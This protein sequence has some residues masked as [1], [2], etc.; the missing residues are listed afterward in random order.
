[1]C[2]HDLI[3]PDFSNTR[4]QF[5]ACAVPAEMLQDSRADHTMLEQ[6]QREGRK[7]LK[8]GHQFA[9]TTGGTQ[10]MQHSGVWLHTAH[11][12]VTLQ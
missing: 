10:C 3:P 8:L 7:K 2:V 9:L 11:V 5:V 12:P 6:Q 4:K 1:V